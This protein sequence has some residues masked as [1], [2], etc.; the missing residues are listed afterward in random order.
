MRKSKIIIDTFV[1][2]EIS[3]SNELKNKEKIHFLQYIWYLTNSE[4]RE[5]V[6]TI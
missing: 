1:L 2:N 3:N 4:K 5:L 6:R